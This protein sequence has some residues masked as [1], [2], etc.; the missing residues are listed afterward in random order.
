MGKK[1]VILCGPSL[2]LSGYGTHTRQVA[3]Y[4]LDHR[5]DIDASFI[6][7]DW[8]NTPWMLD[9]AMC[10]GLVGRIMERT[11]V[12]DQEMRFAA[13]ISV[14][15]PNEWSR[16]APV[17]VGV[18]A[19]VETD[20]CN[21]AWL[22]SCAN[23]DL[24]IVPS[25]H[26]KNVLMNTGTLLKPVKVVGESYNAACVKEDIPQPHA[27]ETDFN[28]LMVGQLTGNNPHND[29]K[30]TFNA[31]KW[32]CD[33][34]KNDKDV[35][36]V[37]K[38]NSGRNSL[39]DRMHTTAAMNSLL[40]EVRKGPFPQ[41]YLLHGEMTEDEVAALY[42]H[43]TVKALVAPT[44]GEGFGLPI[45]EAAV[46]GIPVIATG[47]SGHLDFMGLGRFMSVRY[48]LRD[49][50]TSR[51]DGKIFVKAARWAEPNEEDFKRQVTKFR[52]SPSIPQGWAKELQ[53]RVKEKFSFDA[54]C[55]AYDDALK[56]I[57]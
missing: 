4:L 49:V 50:H 38:T 43:P 23:M 10:D 37:L 32:M 35:G 27:F 34:F 57:I 17:N 25:E 44:R 48:D 15:L 51:V 16:L 26:I 52:S 22:A 45:L 47:W 7:T 21:P 39:I 55:R 5:P 28:F 18:S 56:G 13:S 46:S 19:C 12:P 42:R 2:T 9:G 40:T 54:V 30:N 31:V 41:F 24:V 14:Q 1:K 29:R 8:G 6:T 33:T 36:I 53:P 20:R 3:R 11:V